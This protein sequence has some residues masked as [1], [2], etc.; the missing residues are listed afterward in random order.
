[1]PVLVAACAI[2]LKSRLLF[3]DITPDPEMR[4]VCRL[5]ICGH[6]VLL[7]NTFE[8]WCE[9]EWFNAEQTVRLMFSKGGAVSTCTCGI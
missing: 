9:V 6:F 3:W 4:G 2:I 1:M 7:Q 8:N 5:L